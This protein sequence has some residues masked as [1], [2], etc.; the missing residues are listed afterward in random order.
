[1]TAAGGFGW[2]TALMGTLFVA[3]ILAS[4]A[5]SNQQTAAANRTP[6]TRE[7]GARHPT[8]VAIPAAGFR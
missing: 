2:L 1:M 4:D 3:F 8:L 7:A 6:R 5:K